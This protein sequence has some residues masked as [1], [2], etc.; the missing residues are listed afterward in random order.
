MRWQRMGKWALSLAI[1]VPAMAQ[2]AGPIR[3]GDDRSGSGDDRG[4][5]TVG[6]GA[7]RAGGPMRIGDD[8]RR[9]PAHMRG[10]GAGRG[11]QIDKSI[12]DPKRLAEELKLEW[13]QKQD[14]EQ[15]F[16]EYKSALDDLRRQ[17]SGSGAEQKKKQLEMELKSA[18]AARDTQRA[19]E[20]WREL[21]ELRTSAADEERQ[22]QEMLIEEI[23][24]ILDDGQKVQFRQL[25][26]G[27][28]DR[29]H[30]AG[31]L[32]DPKVLAQ[33]LQQVKLQDYQKS[34]LEQIRKR[35]EQDV[36]LRGENMRPEDEKMMR[37]RLL[38]EVL[39]V[40]DDEQEKQLRAAHA[41]LGG[42]GAGGGPIDLS[43]PG[44]LYYAL[45]RLRTTKHRLSKEQDTEISRLRRQFMMDL[46]NLPRG[47]ADARDRANEQLGQQI[48]MVLT[49]EQREAIE[50]MEMPAGRSMGR[51]GSRFGPRSTDDDRRDRGSRRDRYRRDRE[52]R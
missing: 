42:P 8:G 1:A 9:G 51:R 25:L 22:Y 52:D 35:Y 12:L 38:D 49:P 2:P 29:G 7:P 3:T 31:P 32:D 43:N 50:E 18:R 36:K 15:L 10:Y 14:I 16:R 11:Q 20:I 5:G 47:D 40:L 37:K 17:H 46:R 21:R 23:E 41:K 27:G 6:G 48:L 39:M 28:S 34:Q 26:R 44:H 19:N 4:R 30:A 45:G 24:K 13:R 33:C